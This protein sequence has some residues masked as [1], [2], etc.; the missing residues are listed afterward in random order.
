MR[1]LIYLNPLAVHHCTLAVGLLIR[2]LAVDPRECTAKG[3]PRSIE[4]AFF[5]LVLV[6]WIYSYNFAPILPPPS[7]KTMKQISE[8]EEKLLTSSLN[9]CPE[10]PWPRRH[11][12][13]QLICGYFIWRR[14]NRYSPPSWPFV[15][16]S[17]EDDVY[18]TTSVALVSNFSLINR[19][20]MHRIVLSSSLNS[21]TDQ[22][23]H[24]KS[25]LRLFAVLSA[26]ILFVSLSNYVGCCASRSQ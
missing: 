20:T 17:F 9:I 13:S 21:P 12:I 14:R 22:Y 4:Q 5:V 15:D 16:I 18:L 23:F 8:V 7:F 3:N 10:A 26:K 6:A 11:R 1:R 2:W 19:C 25:F 24:D